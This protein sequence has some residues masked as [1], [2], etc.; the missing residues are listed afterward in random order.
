MPGFKLDVPIDLS[1]QTTDKLDLAKKIIHL[2]TGATTILTICVVAPLISTEARYLGAGLPGP[3]YTLFVALFTLVTPFLLVYF[4]YMYEHHNKFKRFGKFCMKSRTNMIFCGFNTFLWATAGIAITVHSNNASNCAYNSDLTEAYGADY[5]SAWSTQCNLAKVSAAFAW[6]TCILWLVTLGI[7]SI[8]LWKEKTLIQERLNEHRINKQQKLEER[9]Q[10]EDEEMRVA[11]GYAPGGRLSGG[12][13]ED[14]YNSQ[15][16]HNENSAYAGEYHNQT[17]PSP[18]PPQQQPQQ[19]QHSPFVNPPVHHQ[20]MYDATSPYNRQSYIDPTG[21]N[22]VGQYAG[23][24]A[25]ATNFSPMPTPQHMPHP[26]PTYYNHN[27][28]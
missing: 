22:P 12:F 28:F 13:Y 6:I 4:P 3:N 1:E 26:E 25:A 10:Q 16:I 24:H 27:N 18:P 14:E 19:Q 8:N 2:V 11:A 5:T 20:P 7:T 17:S 15:K 23:D 9:R 21:F